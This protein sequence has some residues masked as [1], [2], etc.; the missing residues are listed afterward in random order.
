MLLPFLFVKTYVSQK[1]PGGGF[2]FS[3][4]FHAKTW[5]RT[6]QFDD[7]NFFKW[8]WFNHQ[9]PRKQPLLLISI[10]FTPKNS[11]VVA[12]QKWYFSCFF[13]VDIFPNKKS[14]APNLFCPRFNEIF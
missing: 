5:G 6:I 3:F 10:N 14:P 9:L 11:D 12:Q 4:N 1:N 2:K 8:G 7:H 13:Q